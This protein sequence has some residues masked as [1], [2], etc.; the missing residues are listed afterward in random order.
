MFGTGDAAWKQE[1]AERLLPQWGDEG[2]C[3]VSSA[4][5][6][7]G[8]WDREEEELAVDSTMLPLLLVLATAA[9]SRHCKRELRISRQK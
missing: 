8:S 3:C 7:G 6:Q 5:G 4:N 9:I 2:T 1:E